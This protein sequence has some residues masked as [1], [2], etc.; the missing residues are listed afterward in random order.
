MFIENIEHDFLFWSP[1][2]DK[3]IVLTGGPSW[4][5][6]SLTNTTLTIFDVQHQSPEFTL[7]NGTW[8]NSVAWSLD[9]NMIVFAE[10][11]TPCWFIENCNGEDSLSIWRLTILTQTEINKWELL[12]STSQPLSSNSWQQTSICQLAMLSIGEDEIVSYQ[13]HCAL[14]QLA[15][16]RNLFI[17]TINSLNAPLQVSGELYSGESKYFSVHPLG[18]ENQF[19]VAFRGDT[20]GTNKKSSNFLDVYRKNETTIALLNREILQDSLFS[21]PIVLDF[22]PNNKYAIGELED[23]ASILVQVNN[24][25]ATS[26]LIALPN[27][28][29][30]GLWLSE[31]YLTQ[32]EDRMILVDPET[33]EWEVVQDNLPENF[34]LVGWH[35]PGK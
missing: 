4:E 3:L 15:S 8:I 2:G 20:F 34:T 16:T 31:G 24:S 28:S 29:L 6:E 7:N 21:I 26:I 23:T 17:T 30:K 27:L 22:S 13:S 10:L 32:S 18:T 1:H 12:A 35:I 9:S 25:V 11:E 5:D 33:G 19:V 14:G